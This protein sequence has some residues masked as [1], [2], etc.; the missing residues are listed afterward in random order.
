MS[1][2]LEADDLNKLEATVLYLYVSPQFTEHI[3]CAR[4]LRRRL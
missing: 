4:L 3:G 1:C 2:L